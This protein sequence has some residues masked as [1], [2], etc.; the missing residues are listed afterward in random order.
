MGAKDSA[1][2][3]GQGA[4]F[5]C[6]LGAS[7]CAWLVGGLDEPVE[8]ADASVPPPVRDA[9]PSCPGAL[10]GFPYR[11]A[12]LVDLTD[13][14][15]GDYTVSV[16]LPTDELVGEGKL[17][18]S[19][20]D[21]RFTDE[22]GRPIPFW[23]DGETDG[24]P[25]RALLRMPVRGG[26]RGWVH[27]GNPVALSE[28]RRMDVFVPGVID[29]PTFARRD[30]WHVQFSSEPADGPAEWSVVYEDEGVRFKVARRSGNN[31]A[32]TVACQTVTFPGGSR[33]RLVFDVVFAREGDGAVW[34][35]VSALDRLSVWA[36]SVVEGS[37]AMRAR[38]EQTIAFDSGTRV[39]C[40]GAGVTTGGTVDALYSRIRVLRVAPSEP[41]VLLGSEGAPCR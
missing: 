25:H 22:S 23:V 26:A 31:G 7:G 40:L 27:Y 9:A 13:A 39:V 24:G 19:G 11:R 1:R 37:V 4:L 32:S 18:P 15:V 41:R 16:G 14:S 29:D 3:T 30:A 33:Y 10:P 2:R 35:W 28:S 36:H 38:D 20:A 12:L 17:Q 6:V 8:R 21:Y 5:V 34:V